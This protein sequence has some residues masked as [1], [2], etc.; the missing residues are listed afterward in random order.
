MSFLE[1][2]HWWALAL[3]FVVIEAIYPSGVFMAMALA[4]GFM[5]ALYWYYPELT[6]PAQL[7]GFGAFTMV[8]SYIT[9]YFYRKKLGSHDDVRSI[10]AQHM[11]K[12]ITLTMPV[13]NGFGEVELDG[14]IWELKGPDI[15]KGEKAKI[16]GIDHH[17]LV[18]RPLNVKVNPEDQ[19]MH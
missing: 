19:A 2:W 8:L 7:G 3:C 1:F 11:G 5:G 9:T 4:G 12:E 16:I 15:K 10:A 18:V 13:Q 17:A 14:T 6:V